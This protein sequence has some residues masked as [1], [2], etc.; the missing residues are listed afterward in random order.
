MLY[1][2]GFAADPITK[3][4][5]GIIRTVYKLMKDDDTLRLLLSDNDEKAY[6][7]TFEDRAYV[8]NATLAPFMKDGISLIMRQDKRTYR[9]IQEHFAD[10]G[11]EITI[12]MGEDE[13]VALC[14]GR[15]AN[16]DLLLKRFRFLVIR[17]AGNEVGFNDVGP[18]LKMPKDMNP[19][20]K[21]IMPE[22]VNG[23]SSSKVRDILSRDPETQYRDVRDYVTHVTFSAFKRIGLYHQNPPDIEA[24]EVA[25]LKQYAID[26]EKNH[27]GEP[28]V[29]V[30]VVA[31]ND[32]E[33]LLIRRKNFPYKNCWCLPGGFFDLKDADINYAAAR[34][35]KEETGLDYPPDNFHQIKTYAGR[36]DPRMRIVDVAFDVRVNRS[37]MASAVGADDAAEARWFKLDDLPRLG[38]HHKQIIDDWRYSH[39][40]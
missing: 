2:Y 17:R 27:W 4:H 30:D 35:F 14:D 23:I 9:F 8:V 38:F 25:F 12:V 24:Q 32:D 20:V 15:W 26:K 7:T 11:N 3:A 10:H 22:N 21:I 40:R 19:D 33:V 16:Y 31:H 34:E 39:I 37:D 1:I 18:M 36:F 28:S 5:L 13:W 6:P 29:T